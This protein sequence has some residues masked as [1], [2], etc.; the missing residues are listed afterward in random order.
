MPQMQPVAVPV[1][2]PPQ[3]VPPQP[4]KGKLLVPLLIL[5]GLF[6]ITV[7]VIVIFALKH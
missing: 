1:P 2:A 4:G 3:A 5:G 6:V 7:V